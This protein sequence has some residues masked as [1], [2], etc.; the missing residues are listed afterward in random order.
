MTIKTAVTLTT[1]AAVGF[2]F[3]LS[4][5]QKEKE[6]IVSNI[7]AKIFFALTG[8]KIPKKKQSVNYESHY[9]VKD[10]FEWQDAFCF[11]S[12]EDCED[13]IERAMKAAS[14]YGEISV[15]DVC[16]LNKN[17]PVCNYTWVKYGWRQKDIE[18]WKV[19]KVPYRLNTDPKYQ[20]KVLVNTPPMYLTERK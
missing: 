11:E 13:F 1:G 4:I 6:K 18:T 17:A 3:G 2:L 15:T 19:I 8:E 10:A 20:Y 5:D 12:K 16:F 7:R 14:E 9:S